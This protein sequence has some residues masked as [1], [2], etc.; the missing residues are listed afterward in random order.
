MRAMMQCWLA[1]LAALAEFGHAADPLATWTWRNPQALGNALRA[2][3]Y[4][5]GQFVVVGSYG[6]VFTSPD[7][8]AWTAGNSGTTAWLDGVGYGNG[9]F[10]AVGEF[11]TLLTSSNGVLWTMRNPGTAAALSG[12]A[13]GN[14]MF[15]VTGQAT[16]TSPDG[17]TWT[18]R[19]AG[20]NSWLAGVAYG[21]GRFVAVNGQEVVTSLDGI[22]W[23]SEATATNRSLVGVAYGQERFVAVGWT[24]S[25]VVPPDSFADPESDGRRLSSTPSRRGVR[26]TGW[27][28]ASSICTSSDGVSWSLYSA[29]TAFPLLAVAYGNGRFVAVGDVGTIVES[30]VLGPLLEPPQVSAR[31]G[32]R[33]TL[34]GAV[35][36][37]C[38]VQASADLDH[39]TTL[40]NLTLT[41]AT[42]Q[43]IDASGSTDPRR[44]YRAVVLSGP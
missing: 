18:I 5:N 28:P 14:G 12:V 9:Q 36:Q 4:G 7:T 22:T 29:P 25:V 17:V 21:N 39:W 2:A 32:A 24:Y 33:L 37:G 44:F 34:N 1:A 27:P 40:T 19:N 6:T 38:Q 43:I 35:G 15:V 11:G 23:T 31:G 20:T 16:L 26:P 3:C 13:Y 30:G 8:V 41:N 42:G 10:V